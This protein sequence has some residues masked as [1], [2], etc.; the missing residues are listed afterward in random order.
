MEVDKYDSE[1]EKERL[2]RKERVEKRRKEEKKKEKLKE[3][4]PKEIEEKQENEFKKNVEELKN[5][6]ISEWD[7]EN[8]LKEFETYTSLRSV[9]FDIVANQPTMNLMIRVSMGYEDSFTSQIGKQLKKLRRM[10]LVNEV[11]ICESWW[12]NHFNEKFKLKL[13]IPEIELQMLKKFK[14]H[15][16]T[17]ERKRNSLIANSG[18]WLLTELGERIFPII[19]KS[20]ESGGKS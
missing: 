2:A 3:L 20:I 16:D 7:D 18:F 8:I 17:E 4:T 1:Y 13:K 10:G 5:N 6:P 19:K 9:F 15:K 12:K 11:L 14:L